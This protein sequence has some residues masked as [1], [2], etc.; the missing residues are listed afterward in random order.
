M[1]NF[2]RVSMMKIII[3][4]INCSRDILTFNIA[5]IVDDNVN[6]QNNFK[7][8]KSKRKLEKYFKHEENVATR[9]TGSTSTS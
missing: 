4:T 6:C 8:L 5:A 1:F 2:L 3:I 9:T 7:F